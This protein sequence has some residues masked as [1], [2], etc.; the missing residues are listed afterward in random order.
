M[1]ESILSFFMS[2]L[3]EEWEQ[4]PVYTRHKLLFPLSIQSQEYQQVEYYFYGAQ[5]RRIQRFQNPFQY[6][7]YILRRYML[8]TTYEV[9]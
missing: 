8:Q 7:R 6:G 1:E 9:I 5:I 4:I 3:P 2:N